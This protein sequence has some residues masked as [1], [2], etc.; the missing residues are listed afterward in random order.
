MADRE[1]FTMVLA[2]T[3]RDPAF[4]DLGSDAR[5][6]FLWALSNPDAAMCGLYRATPTQMANALQ[7]DGIP[8][9]STVARVAVA[10]DQLEVKPLALYDEQTQVLWVVNRARHANRSPACAEHMAREI[11]RVPECILRRRFRRAYPGLLDA[12]G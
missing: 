8:A 10:L 12:A 2:R 6:L 7:R 9:G 5:L 11:A 3:W 4:I 1:P